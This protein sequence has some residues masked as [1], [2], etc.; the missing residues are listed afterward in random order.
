M[1]CCEKITKQ[2]DKITVLYLYSSIKENSNV[3]NKYKIILTGHFQ[4]VV[5]QSVKKNSE[6]FLFIL[7]LLVSQAKS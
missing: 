4:G 7:K 5:L 1:C 6:G 2:I 3:K